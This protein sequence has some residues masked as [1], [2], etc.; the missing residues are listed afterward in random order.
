MRY[1]PLMAVGHAPRDLTVVA[2]GI[3]LLKPVIRLSLSE[4]AQGLAIYELADELGEEGGLDNLKRLQ[5]RFM[6]QAR[7]HPHLTVGLPPVSRALVEDLDSYAK[8][9]LGVR[10][11]PDRCRGPAAQVLPWKELATEGSANQRLEGCSSLTA[12][13]RRGARGLRCRC[14]PRAS[15]GSP[16]TN[17]SERLSTRPMLCGI[18]VTTIQ[19]IVLARLCTP[20]PRN[21][22]RLAVTS[23]TLHE[24][25][26]RDRPE[27][28]TRSS[29]VP[30][31]AMLRPVGASWSQGRSGASSTR[32]LRCRVPVGR[33]TGSLGRLL[34]WPVSSVASVNWPCIWP[35]GSCRRSALPSL[36][37]R[38]WW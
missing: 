2:P 37:H 19:G 3:F 38:R 11:L 29:T 22:R 28:C 6:L 16:L 33:S 18:H 31:I 25:W 24:D 17:T 27:R 30:C 14:I 9:P 10:C 12:R 26:P 7:E 32:T 8:V 23:V 34:C 36:P 35:G 15:G 4:G 5:H 21:R 13:R 1:K 20:R